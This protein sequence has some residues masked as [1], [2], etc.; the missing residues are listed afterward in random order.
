L[1]V[2]PEVYFIYEHGNLKAKIHYGEDI[3][4][5]PELCVFM[6]NPLEKTSMIYE[7]TIYGYPSPP[8]NL[9]AFAEI[10]LTHG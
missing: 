7:E 9:L 10:I 1:N 3:T 2:Q 8:E 4:P 6:K 5:S